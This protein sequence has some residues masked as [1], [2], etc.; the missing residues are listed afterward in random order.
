MDLVFEKLVEINKK[1]TSI[2]LVEQ[3]VRMTLEV[4]HRCYP[5]EV[6][7]ISKEGTKAEMIENERVEKPFMGG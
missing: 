6:G 3:N 5:F 7:A 1:G 4:C 2:L